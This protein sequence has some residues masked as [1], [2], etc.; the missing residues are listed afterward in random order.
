V[1]DRI[2]HTIVGV[3]PRRF[4]FPVFNFKGEM[5]SPLKA[6]VAS[7]SPRMSIVAVGR[8]RAG[9]SYREAEAELGT[10]LGRIEAAHPERHQGLG[11]RVVEMA[12]L[13]RDQAV[14]VALVVTAAGGPGALLARAPV[15]DPLLPPAAA[16]QRR[17]AL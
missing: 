13:S 17:L 12:R 1:I 14:P 6:D 4:E 2:G 5:W 16:R 11:P 7:T 10:M 3:M 8:L 15:A 9:V